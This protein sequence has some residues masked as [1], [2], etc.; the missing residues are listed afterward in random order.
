MVSIMQDDNQLAYGTPSQRRDALNR[1]KALGVEAVRVTL[2]W[3][4][5]APDSSEK[6]KPRGFNGADPGDYPARHWDNF[7]DLVIAAKERGIAVYL[8]PTG[9]GP[10]WA[11][12]TT[13]SRLQRSWRP[14]PVEFGKFVRAA[15]RRYSGKYVDENGTK[16]K[17]PRVDWWAIWNEGNQPGWLSPQGAK[18]KGVGRIALSPHLY[19]DL[20][21]AGARALRRTGHADDLVLIGETAPLGEEKAK[22]P[23]SA[24]RPGLFLREMFCLNRR[25]RSYRGRA[26]E[27]RNCDGVGKLDVLAQF[28][29][30]GFGHH[31]YTKKLS[32]RKRDKGRDAMTM[33]NIGSLPRALDKI[34]TRTGL[35]PQDMPVFLTEYGYETSPPDP[36]SG[37]SEALQAE[38]L[39]EGDYIAWK[40]PR[41]F[42]NA[43][44]QL[45]DVPPREEFPRDSTAYWFTYQSGLFTARPSAKPKPA[46]SAYAFPLVARQKGANARIWGQV[47]FAPNGATQEVVL[48]VKQRGSQS[49]KISGGLI[50]VTHSQGYFQT[51]RPSAAGATW[52]AVWVE[53]DRSGVMFSREA[54]A[55]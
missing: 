18:V 54:V 20:L 55:R 30:L 51:K 47:R 50:E 46:A 35:L 42:S 9:S 2:L 53:P 13:G 10:R 17:L 32:P 44:F 8:N 25:Y 52:R 7:D 5:L 28:P 4:A 49:W 48:Q 36:F 27:A 45:F 41:I 37:V 34:A 33:A 29:R 26:A 14:D 23:G 31:P 1:M 39:N 38:Y 24:L 21:V 11:H 6:K 3:K 40:H 16:A 15:G 12:G 22:G 43:Q 19:R